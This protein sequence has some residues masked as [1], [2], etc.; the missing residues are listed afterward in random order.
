VRSPDNTGARSQAIERAG[1]YAPFLREAI[2]A[3]PDIAETFLADG[4]QAASALAIRS[5]GD[6]AEAQLRLRRLAL[7]LAVALGDLSGELKLEEVTR[8]LSE[9]ADSS[10]ERAIEVAMAEMFEAEPFGG[11]QARGFAVIALGKLGSFEL[12]FSSDVDLLLLFDPETLPRRERD[13]PGNAAVRIGRRM[14]ELLQKRTRDGYVAR[15]D[16]R[17]RP[18]PEATPIALP[19]NAAISYYESSAVGWERAAFIRARCCAGD[20]K[21]GTKFLK[22]IEPFVWRRALDFGAI[23]EVRSISE[24]IRDHHS[25]GQTFGPG[26]DLKRGRGG[27]REVEFY[28]HAQQLVHGGR[29]PELRSPATLDALEALAGAGYLEA[30]LAGEL[31]EAYRRL[32]TAEHR[33]QMVEDQQTHLI[34]P[35]EEALDN[36]AALHGFKSGQSLLDWLSPWVERVGSKFDELAGED[37]ERVAGDPEKLWGELEALGFEEPGTAA[38]RVEEWRSGRPRSLRSPAAKEAFEAMLPALLRA[39]AKSDDPMR[40]LNRLSDV[41]ERVPSGVNLYRLLEARP[42]LSTLLAR[43]LAHAPALSDQL[44][45]RPELLDSLLDSSCFEPPLAAAEFAQFLTGEMDG[46]PY[47]VALDAAR[48]I[49]N[50]RRFA[51]GVQLIDLSEPPLKIGEGYAQIAEGALVA[52][53]DKAVAEFE[54]AHGRFPGSEL[55]ILGL[56]RLGGQ[57]LTNASD[58]DIIYLFTDPKGESSTGPKPLGPADYF[59]RLANRINAAISVP[60]PAGPLYEV[61]TRLRP[62]GAQGMLA[63]SMDAFARYQ[64]TEAWTWEH[65]A[66]AR[67][68][69]VYGSPKSRKQARALISDILEQPRDPGKLIADAVKMREE[70]ARHKPP[71]GPLDVKLREGGLVDLE[72]AVHVLQLRHKK[73]LHP[74]LECAI[75][76]LVEAGLVPATIAKAQHLLTEMLVTIRLIAPE[77]ARPTAE[78]CELMAKACGSESWDEL[79][80]AHEKARHSISELW[81]QVKGGIAK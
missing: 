63:V 21:V 14:I 17:L 53:A 27:I 33:V 20:R 35:S 18:S 61:D 74:R 7:A 32:R 44:A 56:G 51:L 43:I 70:I 11:E 67:A 55:V 12:N 65:M 57:V 59:N 45:R 69:P 39:I 19:V 72:F 52:L 64:H 24:Q 73:G 4:A 75:A 6:S 22:A 9:F 78:S 71:S 34:P 50:E 42:A 10:I 49:I 76:Q 38:R 28:A 2:S 66:L 31:G 40:A 1:A 3:R 5:E 15:V 62:Q 46:R 47:D 25:K 48:R 26:Y 30:D 54:T 68:R 80:E 79:L 41:V 37:R 77:S 58:L 13:E 81:N 36:V 23:E 29:Q 8:L 60:T 16:L